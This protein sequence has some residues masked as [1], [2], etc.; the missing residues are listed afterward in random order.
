MFE[1]VWW[2]AVLV[3]ATAARAQHDCFDCDGAGAMTRPEFD[4]KVLAAGLYTPEAIAQRV[5][6]QMVVKCQIAVNGTV[7]A[8]QVL[9]DLPLLTK[10]VL[11]RLHSTKVKPA[12]YGGK[13]VAT[14]YVFNLR[15]S[16]PI[17]SNDGGTGR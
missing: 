16:L 12:T 15:F 5:E 13:P 14:S 17:A 9:K 2:V 11:A 8:C 7:T 4:R 10:A 1:R 3:L 6:G